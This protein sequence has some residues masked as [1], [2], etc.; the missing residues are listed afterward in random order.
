MILNK[1]VFYIG[2][3]IDITFLVDSLYCKLDINTIT[4]RLERKFTLRDYE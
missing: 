3:V 4:T 1:R 2:D